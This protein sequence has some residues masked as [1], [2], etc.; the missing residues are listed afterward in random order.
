MK[1]NFSSEQTEALVRV[2]G[3]TATRT[4]LAA[5]EERL[6]SRMDG[7]ETRLRAEITRVVADSQTLMMRWGITMIVSMATIFTLLD[8]FID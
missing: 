1:A 3:E 6:V 5:M 7:M 8:I 4:E 2:L